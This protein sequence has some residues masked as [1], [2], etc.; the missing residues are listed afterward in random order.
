VANVL[1]AVATRVAERRQILLVAHLS[2]VVL[3]DTVG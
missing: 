1:N 3:P 2:I